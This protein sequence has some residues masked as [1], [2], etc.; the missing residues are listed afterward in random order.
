[1]SEFLNLIRCVR[2]LE[3]LLYSESRVNSDYSK[4]YNKIVNILEDK[5]N[6]SINELYRQ[7]RDIRANEETNALEALGFFNRFIDENR[8]RMDVKERQHYQKIMY[9]LTSGMWL[10]SDLSY[11]EMCELGDK[12]IKK[13]ETS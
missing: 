11:F 8:A 12:L 4:M 1:M 10:N 6:L 3:H 9:P 5:T 13:Y 7:I 2:C